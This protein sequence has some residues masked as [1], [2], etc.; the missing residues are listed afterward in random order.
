MAALAGLVPNVARDLLHALLVASA[1]D[2]LIGSL[3]H[4]IM[5]LVT[6]CAGKAGVKI[7]IRGGCLV[8]A[9]AGLGAG[10]GMRACRVR[11]VTA[12]AGAGVGP[13]WMVGMNVLVAV[14]AGVRGCALD[15]VRRVTAAALVVRL[16]RGP[17]EHVQVVMAGAASDCLALCETVG[18]MAADALAV[19]AF[20]ESAA[21]HD[22]LL[23]GVTRYTGGP[24]V[25][26]RRVLMLVARGASFV[27]GLARGTVTRVDV[28]V[29]VVAG[30][31][32]RLVVFVRV[33]ARAAFLGAVNLNGGYIALSLEMTALAVARRED[34]DAVHELASVRSILGRCP[35]VLRAFDRERVTAHTVGLHA[36]PEAPFGLTLGM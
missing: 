10:A 11:V 19:T 27:N 24:C 30:R 28:L 20:E 5:R 9:A 14:L 1:A 25:T 13:R 3:T 16:V 22:R 4:E 31:G 34:F 17:A 12:H 21:G 29:A 18:T 15:V 23:L 2:R 6:L 7:V 36:R 32:L 33:M 8:A 35:R 26:G